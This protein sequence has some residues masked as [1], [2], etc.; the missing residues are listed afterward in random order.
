MKE[1]RR[2][3]EREKDGVQKPEAEGYRRIQEQVKKMLLFSLWQEHYQ[4]WSHFLPWNTKCLQ[5]LSRIASLAVNTKRV[6]SIF[7]T[8][9]LGYFVWLFC[10]FKCWFE[11]RWW[12]ENGSRSLH[13]DL[14]VICRFSKS[15]NL[16]TGNY[17]LYRKSRNVSDCTQCHIAAVPSSELAVYCAIGWKGTWRHSQPAMSLLYTD[18]HQVGLRT[19]RNKHN[20][21]EVKAG[22]RACTE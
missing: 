7:L 14:P 10:S 15:S 3:R 20:P 19:I 18:S 12:W 6:T 16:H 2:E 11:C 9:P 4:L 1:G 8:S 5:I 13:K 22:G 21:L 17:V